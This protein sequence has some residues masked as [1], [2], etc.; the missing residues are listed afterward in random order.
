MHKIII[1]IF[2]LTAYFLLPDAIWAHGGVNDDELIIRMAENGF[3]PRELTVTESD[4]VLFINNDDVDR[5]PASNFHPTHTLYPEFDSLK[6][7]PPGESWKVKFGKVGTWRMHDHLFPH[8][9]G[10]IVVLSDPNTNAT[11]SQGQTLNTDLPA[12]KAGSQGLTLWTKI[13]AFF[14]KLFSKEKAPAISEF[15]NLPEREKYAWLENRAKVES[16]E[17]AWRYVK[18]AYNTPEGVVG[19]PHDMAHLVGQLIYKS[20]G[21]DGLTICEPIFAF[22]CYHGLIE[23][24]FDKDKPEAYSDKLFAAQEGCKSL[25]DTE[26]PSYWS[27]IHGMGHGVATFREYNMEKSLNDCDLLNERVRTY[28]HDGVFM[29]FSISAPASFYKKERPIYPCDTVAEDYKTSCARSQVQV[30]R[31]RFKMNTNAIA[32]TCID[33]KNTKIIYH[34]TD[35]LGYFIAQT[36]A[37]NPS[38]IIANCRDITNE[39]SA[40]Q[41]TAAAAGELIFQ[42]YVGWQDSVK[43]ICGSLSEAYQVDCLKRVEQV[44]QSYGRN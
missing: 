32:R 12:G 4:E 37:G 14:L 36:S 6:G 2:I 17:V 23:V 22:G 9:T 10:T 38:K 19:N 42:N 27:C 15:K 7:V 25:G 35:A 5:W 11:T 44:K 20:Y 43:E 40:A 8:M 18:E 39:K 21:F 33:T 26:T 1:F 3:E 28:C 29:E 30:M 24:A 31:L 16:P 41:C 13:K 34:C